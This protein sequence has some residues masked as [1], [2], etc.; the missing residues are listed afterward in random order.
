MDEYSGAQTRAPIP[1]YDA[2]N[3]IL[4]WFIQCALW[5]IEADG[6]LVSH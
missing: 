4:N 1:A 5:K 3:R 2:D 6:I